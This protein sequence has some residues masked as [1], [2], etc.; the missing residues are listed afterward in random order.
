MGKTRK[1]RVARYCLCMNSEAIWSPDGSC[2]HCND[3]G[4][5]DCSEVDQSL[6]DAKVNCSLGFISC[7][8]KHDEA[9]KIEEVVQKANY[10]GAENAKLE[11]GS[12]WQRKRIQSSCYCNLDATNCSLGF[13]SCPLKHD[14]AVKIEEVVQKANYQGAENAKLEVKNSMTA[15][16]AAKQQGAKELP[17]GSVVG[18]PA[19]SFNLRWFQLVVT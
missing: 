7:P 4:G 8:L 12:R 17:K 5:I 10:Q 1:A 11:A 14:E 3:N 6:L 9:V 13:I 19:R 16:K 18:S 2:R 15:L